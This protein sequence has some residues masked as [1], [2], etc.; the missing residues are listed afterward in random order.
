MSRSAFI[1]GFFFDSVLND[2]ADLSNQLK[3]EG[4][5]AQ[6]TVPKI[7]MAAAKR[8]AD[9]RRILDEEA[10]K[11]GWHSEA[12]SALNDPAFKYVLYKANHTSINGSKSAA[13]STLKGLREGR[14]KRWVRKQYLKLLRNIWYQKI[15]QTMEHP[16]C[17]N[18]PELTDNLPRLLLSVAKR[19]RHSKWQKYT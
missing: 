12:Q 4:E 9:L 2:L 14:G 5:L 18:L 17:V 19:F 8:L 3:A 13:E 1:D 10:D 16:N 15:L 11:E 6:G 7:R